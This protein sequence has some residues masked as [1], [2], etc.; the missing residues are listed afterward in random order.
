[1][2]QLIGFY[3]ELL[4]RDYFYYVHLQYGDRIFTEN[5]LGNGHSSMI[6]QHLSKHGCKV[7]QAILN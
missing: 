5:G 4:W 1:M 7:K 3:F 6:T 2:S